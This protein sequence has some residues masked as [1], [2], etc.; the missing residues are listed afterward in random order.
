[1]SA[2]LRTKPID[3]RRLSYEDRSSYKPGNRASALSKAKAFK[4]NWAYSKKSRPFTSELTAGTGGFTGG[5]FTQQDRNRQIGAEERRA[6][7]FR[8]ETGIKSEIYDTIFNVNDDA[9]ANTTKD[10][11]QNQYTNSFG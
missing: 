7:S 8:P 3:K 2:D 6:K 9:F 4:A 11:W 1:M 10:R 5:L